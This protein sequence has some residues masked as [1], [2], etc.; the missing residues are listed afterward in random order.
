MI[1]IKNI[2]LLQP[3]LKNDSRNKKNYEDFICHRQFLYDE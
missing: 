1:Y 2:V 3:I